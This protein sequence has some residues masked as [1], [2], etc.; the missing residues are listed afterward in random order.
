MCCMPL[1]L[2]LCSEND[3][4][5]TRHLTKSVWYLNNPTYSFFLDIDDCANV[6]CHNLRTCIDGVNDYICSCVSGYS[7][8]HC[9][10]GRF[11]QM[12]RYREILGNNSLIYIGI[13]FCRFLRLFMTRVFFVSW[14]NQDWQICVCACQCFIKEA[15]RKYSVMIVNLLIVNRYNEDHKTSFCKKNLKPCQKLNLQ[16]P[17]CF[18]KTG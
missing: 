13:F 4:F 18:I 17:S 10:T 6:T 8:Q 12:C 5:S 15:S 2:T 16:G 3:N 7:G 14:L 9:E 1:A 11:L